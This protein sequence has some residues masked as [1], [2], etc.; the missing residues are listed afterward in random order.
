MAERWA[1]L[2]GRKPKRK[3]PRHYESVECTF[4]ERTYIARFYVEDGW[5]YVSSEFGT[6]KAAIGKLVPSSLARLLV[7]ELYQ[8]NK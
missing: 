8:K 4:D 5:V 7:G 1:P 2:R 3:E 6:N